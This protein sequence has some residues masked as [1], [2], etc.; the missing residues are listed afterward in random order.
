MLAIISKI[1]KD[2]TTDEFGKDFDLTNVAGTIGFTVGMVMYLISQFTSL[3]PR[4]DLSQF[5]LGFS[6]LLIAT[7]VSQR[8]KPAAVVPD[9]S[10]G[11]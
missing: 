8:V 2:C 6:G 5:A 11:T 3:L 9:V 7:G 1:L 10:K 4:F